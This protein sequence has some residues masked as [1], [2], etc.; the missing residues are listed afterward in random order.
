MAYPGFSAL[1]AHVSRNSRREH[2]GQP[3][4]VIWLPIKDSGLLFHTEYEPGEG[5]NLKQPFFLV[6]IPLAPSVSKF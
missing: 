6:H 1:R 2:I 4:H 3:F 5:A